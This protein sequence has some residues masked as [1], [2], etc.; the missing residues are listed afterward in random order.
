MQIQCNICSQPSSY[1]FSGL[2]L[3]KYSVKYFKC[4]SC[5]FIQTEQPYWLNEAYEKPITAL[6]LGYVSRNLYYADYLSSFLLKSY[7]HFNLDAQFLDYGG[8]YGMFVRLM[9][10]KG[11]DFYREDMYCENL[12][13]NYFDVKNLTEK[14]NFDLLTCFEVFEHLENPY[15]DIDKM[16]DYSHTIFFSTTLQPE[17]KLTSTNDWDYFAPETG[18]HISFYT[19]SSLRFI[20]KKYGL[21][22]YSNANITHIL[23]DKDLDDS[24][25]DISYKRLSFSRKLKRKII[26]AK[27]YLPRKSSLLEH[28]VA[29]VKKQIHNHS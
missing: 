2:V 11:F 6:D 7:I 26:G 5:G 19:L 18:Q 12:F 29:H 24:C 13:A 28:D 20:A 23:T 10:D 8:G 14:T 1:L 22:L 3:N 9:R 27:D 17:I 4:K 25:L 21:N 16:L 15:A